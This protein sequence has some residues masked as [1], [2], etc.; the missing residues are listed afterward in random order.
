[1]ANIRSGN[2]NFVLFVLKSDN[3]A[4]LEMLEEPLGWNDDE[5]ELTRHIK[6]HGIFTKFTKGLRFHSEAKD[7]IENAYVLGGL[8]TNLRLTKFIIKDVIDKDGNS[9][10]K[11]IQRY[12]ALADYN[13]KVI[14][15]NLLEIKFNSNDL[16]EL[17][18]SHE[19]DTFEIERVDSID[20]VNLDKLKLNSIAIK[21]RTLTSAGE[22]VIN[23]LTFKL[24]PD[25]TK[26]QKVIIN[27]DANACL[28]TVVTQGSLRHTAIVTNQFDESDPSEGDTAAAMF[29]VDVVAEGATSDIDFNFEFKV[30][31]RRVGNSPT[32]S[33]IK[34]DLVLYEW[35]GTGYDEISVE[36]IVDVFP[37][38]DNWLTVERSG[39]RKFD[40]VKFNQGLAFKWHS[41]GDF[42]TEAR[43]FKHT[44]TIDIIDFFEA[45][46]DLSFMF[47]HDIYERLIY[48]L[49]G[50]KNKFYSKFFG[51][52]G[53]KD[54][55]GNELYV[56]DGL[57]DNNNLGGGL[58]GIMSGFWVRDFNPLSEK[59]KSL[60]IS[61]KDLLS[62]C[63]DVFNTGMGIETINFKERL[64][65][66]EQKY[67]YR[68][69]TVVKLPLQISKEK[70]IVDKKLFFSAL[71]LGYSKGGDYENEIGLDEPN[72][73]TEYI[74]PIRKSKN[75]YI[76]NSKIR[77][78]EYGMELIRR[79]PQVSFPDEDT[80]EDEHNWFL[81]LVRDD[82]VIED[83]Y[84]Q[85]EWDDRLDKVPVGIHSPTTFRSMIFTPL[86]IL[87][88]HGW[89]IRSGIEPYLLKNI[90]YISSIA[91]SNL[92]MKFINEQEHSENSDIVVN[93][94]ERSRFLPEI[95]EFEHPVDED[96]IDLI[97]GTT[98]TLVN[99]SLEQVPNFYFKFEW[100]NE[101]EEIERGY[102]LD[103]K[104]KGKGKWKFLIANEN[105][106]NVTI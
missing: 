105:L 34:C 97:F 68:T 69:D 76:K 82:L 33:H 23:L 66:E 36:N 78:D 6:Y 61:L 20:D 17:I 49:T 50:E 38:Q 87:F 19:S 57:D 94:L 26:Y 67:F 72:T 77:A 12:T 32:V 95:I 8:N 59:Y 75:K 41:V 62:S 48:I 31:L 84:R 102:L 104:P 98:E 30:H 54:S 14:K 53:L 43:F 25:G 47:T 96:L 1:M 51:R 81:D 71:T 80:T 103:L 7:Y 40:N 3:S 56:Q 106:L 86:R 93:E 74:T 52:K 22:Q 101:Y 60:Q 73:K 91:N 90:K 45:S 9:D 100:I 18:K 58:I 44:I 24:L 42:R 13:T 99:G 37:I 92:K 11:F 5:L 39:N 63:H 88:R 55:N 4:S 2:S 35:N 70:R 46:P 83:K 10:V 15:G 21:G 89:I 29:F 65:V 79:K 27:N 16:A 28:T 85:A 64:R